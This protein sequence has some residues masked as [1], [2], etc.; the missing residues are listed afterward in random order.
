MK[1]GT[2]V[3][4]TRRNGQEATGRVYGPVWSAGK[5]DWIPVNTALP[6]QKALVTQLRPSQ[7]TKI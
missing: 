6:K 1:I 3:K 7:L 5:G 4:F 2:K